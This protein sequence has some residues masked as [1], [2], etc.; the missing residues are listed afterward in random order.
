L[1]QNKLKLSQ[2]ESQK[3]EAQQK[4]EESQKIE[5]EERQKLIPIQNET[6]ASVPNLSDQNLNVGV[7]QD[8]PH[9]T[10]A[11]THEHN[12]EEHN[13]EHNHHEHSRENNEENTLSEEELKEL[14][15]DKPSEGG[16]SIC[17]QFLLFPFVSRKKHLFFCDCR[18]FPLFL[19]QIFPLFLTSLIV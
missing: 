8:L 12:H 6:T 17:V 2:L 16:I 7:A 3:K 13:H 15:S 1:E 10:E 5:E 14:E 4:L 18:N 9:S 19:F 11:H